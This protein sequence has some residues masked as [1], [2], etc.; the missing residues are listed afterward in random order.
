[1]SIE[2]NSK[3]LRNSE[4]E[5]RK[6]SKKLGSICSSLQSI[7]K[8]LDSDIKNTGNIDR[9]FKNICEEMDQN[10]KNLSNVAEFLSDTAKT[11][12]DAEK[13]I[14][15]DLNGISNKKSSG[16]IISKI[17]DKIKSIGEKVRTI[18]KILG[19]MK[20]ITSP[21]GPIIILSSVKKYFDEKGIAID[22]NEDIQQIEV[23]KV[24]IPELKE[25]LSYDPGTYKEEVLMLQRMLNK[26]EENDALKIKEDGFF[27]KE[28]LA[29]VNRYKEKHGLWNFGEYEGKVG[30]TTWEHLFTNT[31]GMKDVIDKNTLQDITNKTT[32]TINYDIINAYRKDIDI[33]IDNIR[34][35][36]GIKENNEA[37]IDAMYIQMYLWILGYDI[38]TF[39]PAG[40]GVDGSIGGKTKE[41][42]EKVIPGGL[43][44]LKESRELLSE[45]VVPV[46]EKRAKEWEGIVKNSGS[47]L[48]KTKYPLVDPM[49]YVFFQK[50]YQKDID[51]I[52]AGRLAAFARDNN[53]S[54]F[55]GSGYRTYEEQVRAWLDNGGWQNSDGSWG[56]PAD[57]PK[58]VATP[59]NSWHN[60]GEAIDI[61]WN[62]E[63]S[64][65]F[66]RNLYGNYASTE[67]QIELTKYG[68]FKPLTS[69]NK[70]PA[71]E[72]WHIQPI[73]TEGINEKEDREKYYKA[74]K[75]TINK[76]DAQN[77]V[78]IN[79]DANVIIESKSGFNYEW[80]GKYVTDEFKTKVIEICEK[81]KMNPDDLMAIMAFESGFNP[82][83]RNPR[84]G[85]TGLIQWMPETAADYGVSTDDLAKMSAFEQLDYVYKYF[86]PYAGK[87]HDIKDA[88]MVVFMPIAV[89]K[90][91]D[92]ILG[93]KG[94]NK[95]FYDDKTYGDVY[96]NNSILDYD[97]DGV[98]YKWE[99]AK[100]VIE[101]REK[102]K[103]INQ[104]KE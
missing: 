70:M 4:D 25:I 104:V 79:K 96:K 14:K 7:R 16:N 13:K 9:C 61:S 50:Q 48:D 21:I 93:I 6:L 98:I 88:Y 87:I 78:S 49:F 23:K 72:E 28:T 92:Y 12:E 86:K 1:M 73:E 102:Y 80:T 56:W 65:I 82:T 101:T 75:S 30:P 34:K 47:L 5:V 15:K 76:S 35:S 27:G 62:G 44:N 19:W 18:F 94:S 69:G 71:L 81:L 36:L 40:I 32:G 99:A 97:G 26:L 52:F 90:E 29:A 57:K 8:S 60:F 59:G 91:D 103:K 85:A 84:S 20:F 68:I 67:Q 54:I 42:L 89:G 58:T 83:A 22:N 51:P 3:A 45:M 64:S 43:N 53:I 63:P 41:A 10:E 74:Y 17:F 46:L 11:Y 24:E 55:V 2:V 95:I 37:A 31:G 38:G 66:I 77:E 39:G 33:A 100:K